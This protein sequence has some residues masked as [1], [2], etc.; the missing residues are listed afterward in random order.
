VATAN[1]V[2][3]AGARP[4]FVDIKRDD[5]TIDVADLE[6]K[7]TSGSRAVIPVH[8]YG[9]PC[10]MDEL[11]E[12]AGKH[13]LSVIED[14]CQS[15]GSTY[16]GKQT[17][18][19]G[20]MGC[21]SMYASKVITAGEGGAIATN[22]DSLA[23]KLRMIRNH[24]MVEGYDTRIFGL[25]MRLPELCA[26]IAK[27]QMGKL[28]GLLDIR[29]SNAN[30]MSDLLRDCGKLVR[31]PQEGRDS[32]FNWYLYTVAIENA[33]RDMAKST[34]QANGIGT[35]VYYDPPVHQTPYYRMM[36]PE[37]KLPETDWSSKHVLSLPVH[38]GVDEEGIHRIASTLHAALKNP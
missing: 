14:A 24:G 13:S 3:A 7:I 11:L 27:V 38:P 29:R 26:A 31:T 8:L 5:Y 19:F 35:A 9:H 33:A 12:V 25:N 1:A 36:A 15:I 37:T 4:V 18:T 20:I 6:R 17:G 28:A 21:Y 2:V 34:M 22:D 32:K 23:D 16:K 30:M 10:G